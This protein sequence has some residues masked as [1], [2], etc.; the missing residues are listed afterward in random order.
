MSTRVGHLRRFVPLTMTVSTG[1]PR[2]A[3]VVVSAKKGG[4]TIT[5]PGAD[6]VWYNSGDGRFYAAS[7]TASS[8]APTPVLGIIA[9]ETS[10]FLQAVLSG[11][12]AH[13]VSTFAETDQIFVPTG[14][15]TA[16][17][18]TDVCAVQFGLP[19]K[20]GCVFVYAHE[21]EA[22]EDNH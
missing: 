4:P 14:V 11:P 16:T 21:S 7:S 12:G 3:G 8:T 9:A 10:E 20:T 15:P 2:L 17:V 1:I 18:P 22:D 5:I 6:E 19:A 13:S